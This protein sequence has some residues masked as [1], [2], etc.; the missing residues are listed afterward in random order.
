VPQVD[1]RRAQRISV[2]EVGNAPVKVGRLTDNDLVLR[3]IHVSR[4]HCVI[5]KVDGTLRV[6]DL[7]SQSGTWVNGDRIDEA[8]LYAGD[9]I[10][11]GPFDLVMRAATEDIDFVSRNDAL[12]SAL[13]HVAVDDDTGLGIEGPAALVDDLK[14]QLET[15]RKQHRKTAAQVAGLLQQVDDLQAQM[16]AS[17]RSGLLLHEEQP[18]A[19]DER[20]AELEEAL[21]EAQ[22]RAV[23]A[24]RREIERIASLQSEIEP[25]Q[26]RVTQAEDHA[27]DLAQSL[28]ALRRETAGASAAE[29]IAEME[30]LLEIERR[31]AQT[32]EQR[33]ERI[34][35]QLED[36]QRVVASADSAA[37]LQSL[38]DA[39][40]QRADSLTAR[41][42]E[43]ELS[44]QS[45]VA[46]LREQRDAGSQRAQDLQQEIT[47][48]QELLREART[49]SE[50]TAGDHRTAIEQLEELR[51][52]LADWQ[53][54]SEMTQRSLATEQAHA[55]DLNRALEESWHK[56]DEAGTTARSLEARLQELESVQREQSERA[57]DALSGHVSEIER[58]TSNEA[59]LRRQFEEAQT[60]RESIEASMADLRANFESADGALRQAQARASDLEQSSTLLED[61]LAA[62]EREMRVQAEQAAAEITVREQRIADL[63]ASEEG[64]KQRLNN[65]EATKFAASQR[66]ERA[67]GTINLLQGQIR[68]L[69]DAAARVTDLQGR[70]AHVEQAWVAADETLEAVE[71]GD[72]SQIAAAVQQRQRIIAELDALNKARDA[73]VVSLRES[74][75]RLRTISERETPTVVTRQLPQP[76]K[77]G[78]AADGSGKKWWRLKK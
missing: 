62:F 33:V 46:G 21:A 23:N 61:R 52:A 17:E 63:S 16:A 13:K 66:A 18:P 29:Q 67:L 50:T 60:H 55:A 53:S 38:L 45:E 22:V 25:L 24:E 73:A 65:L 19:S 41:V 51:S 20:V 58:L 14:K 69:D 71:E 31:R 76:E 64:L 10:S 35:A 8:V 36:A 26:L 77:V 6:R 74:A 47:T 59:D 42:E 54:R 34:C 37:E 4:H 1:I 5:E 15:E 28:D 30:G 48:L 3:N 75:L 9:R 40:R 57:A 39:E 32:A 2:H 72:Q 68:S 56:I 27:S 7:D 44:L 70:L 12:N 43:L 78:A 11:V 49:A